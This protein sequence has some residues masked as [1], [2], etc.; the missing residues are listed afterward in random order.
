[1]RLTAAE[2]LRQKVIDVLARDV[3]DLLAQVDGRTVRVPAGDVVLRTRGV[4][5]ERALP[6]W[7]H[8]LLS[9][10]ANPSVALI[11]MMIGIYG[12]MFEFSSPGFGV[13]GVVGAI[14]LLLAAFALQLMPVNY[15]GLAL[16]LLGLGLMAAEAYSPTFGVFGVGGVIAFI[17]GGILL[18]DADVPGY[19]VPLSLLFGLAAASAAIVVLGGGMALRARRRPVVS[20][21]EELAGAQGEVLEVDGDEAWA[22][23]RGERW[24]VRADSPLSPGQPVRVVALQGLTLDVKPIVNPGA[25]R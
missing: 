17:A 6:G 22:L 3:A 20:G 4:A 5:H 14:C 7:R 12:L 21:S 25:T 18:F 10:V 8:R 2:A 11:L 16:V 15:A 19:G 1:V 9:V 23:V 24:K 13:P